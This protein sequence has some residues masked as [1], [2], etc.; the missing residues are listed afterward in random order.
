MRSFWGTVS[1]IHDLGVVAEHCPYCGQP[2]SCLLRSVS[3][4]NYILFVKLAEPLRETSCLCTACHKT[5]P[6]K[7]QWHYAEVV[8]IRVACNMP[9]DDLLTKTNP[10]LA[11]RIH[12]NKQIRELGGDDRFAV[13]YEQ[14]E[15]MRPGALRSDLFRKLLDWQQ[16]GDAQQTEISQ[17]IGTL[18]R[19][20]QFARHMAVGFPTSAGCLTYVIAALVAG[21]VL[22]C[23]AGT[24]NWRGGSITTVTCLIV[25]AVVD[26]IM[27][28]QLVSRWTRKVLIPEAQEADVSLDSFFTV[29]DD[30]PGSRLGLTEDLWPMKNQ[31]Q[32]ICRVLTTEGQLPRP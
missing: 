27:L 29:L 5:F 9:L 26:H 7:P 3:Q 14:I 12:F 4:G 22:L 32:T 25:A 19:A 11:D 18:S 28:T 20:W 8:P 13:A 2:T 30:V 6:G 15:G 21:V 10:I 17:R 1:E 23:V 16:L 31:L 24:R